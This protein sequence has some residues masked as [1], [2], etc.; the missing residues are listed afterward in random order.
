MKEEI[1]K[2]LLDEKAKNT[3]LIRELA[4]ILKIPRLHHKYIKENGVNEF[5]EK[6][7]DVVEHHDK[8]EQERDLSQERVRARHFESIEKYENNSMN[9]DFKKSSRDNSVIL[10]KLPFSVLYPDESSPLKI[11]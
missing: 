2:K 5:I 6:C 1:I 11:H 7:R 9:S 4:T 8:T 10:K 3:K